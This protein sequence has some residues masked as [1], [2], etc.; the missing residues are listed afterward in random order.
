MLGRAAVDNCKLQLQSI[1]TQLEFAAAA[2]EF[3]KRDWS[4]HEGLEVAVEV[5]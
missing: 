4:F 1:A 2:R 5:K 3:E